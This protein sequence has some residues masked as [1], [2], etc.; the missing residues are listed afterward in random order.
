MTDSAVEAYR[1][2][3]AQHQAQA[4]PEPE[5]EMAGMQMG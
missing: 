2:A 1:Q 4:D 5:T 3:L